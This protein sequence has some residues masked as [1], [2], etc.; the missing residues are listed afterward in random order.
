MM[1]IKSFKN[2]RFIFWA[3]SLYRNWSLNSSYNRGKKNRRVGSG[4]VVHSRIQFAGNNNFILLEQ[5]AILK[6]CL[7][8]ISGNNNI[9]KIGKECIISGAE[10]WIEDSHCSIIIGEKTFVGHHS[11]LAATENY[12]SITIGNN[13]LISS[14]AQIRTGDSHSI[15]D[16]TGQR[17]NKAASVDIKDHCWIGEGVKILKGTV[18]EM[19]TVVATSSVVTKS[20]GPN[21]LIAGV[22]ATI[23]KSNVSWKSERI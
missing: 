16:S 12:N 15:I 21:Q 11:H 2:I 4:I 17:I 3:V 23:I 10:L 5:G 7:V 1:N 6:N 22:P 9:I 19:N 14:Y 20:F 8:H 13:C 18:L